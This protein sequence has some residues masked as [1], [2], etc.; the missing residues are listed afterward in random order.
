MSQPYG[1]KDTGLLS[2]TVCAKESAL[3]LVRVGGCEPDSGY[4]AHT[5]C[6]LVSRRLK[7]KGYRG[8]DS[9]KLVFG[10]WSMGTARGKIMAL[11]RAHLWL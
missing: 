9:T 3:S 8:T 11:Q 10:R 1:G 4:H 5:D 2:P 7:V 6:S